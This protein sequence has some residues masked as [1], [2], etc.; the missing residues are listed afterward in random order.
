MSIEVFIANTLYRFD[1]NIRAAIFLGVVGG[2]GVGYELHKAMRL[3]RYPEALAVT[4]LI[5]VVLTMSEKISDI[6]R[7]RIIGQEVLQ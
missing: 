4:V 5:L 7:K 6:L 2:G 1:I 3:F